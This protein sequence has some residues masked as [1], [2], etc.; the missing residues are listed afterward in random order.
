MPIVSYD[1]LSFFFLLSVNIETATKCTHRDQHMACRAICHYILEIN[2]WSCRM[3]KAKESDRQH[4]LH[5]A[6]I[7]L[8]DS[9]ELQQLQPGQETIGS[10]TQS[11][12]LPMGIKAPET[13]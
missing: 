3:I 8:P 7:S 6:H 12:L 1:G 9:L 5:S 13:C 2:V 4:P 10:N 11:A